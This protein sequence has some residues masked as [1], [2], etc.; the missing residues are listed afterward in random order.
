MLILAHH[1]V[2]FGIMG[3]N[4]ANEARFYLSALDVSFNV[5]ASTTHADA[6]EYR[7]G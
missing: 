1:M 2:T 6:A 7:L 4:I 3:G 5:D